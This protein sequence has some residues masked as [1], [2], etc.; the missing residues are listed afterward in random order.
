MR[1]FLAIDAV[2]PKEDQ[3]ERE[4]EAHEYVVVELDMAEIFSGVEG[5][6]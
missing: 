6:Q 2:L 5:N 1:G 4:D 3:E